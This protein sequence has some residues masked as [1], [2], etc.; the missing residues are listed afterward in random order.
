MIHYNGNILL[1]IMTRSRASKGILASQPQG[2]GSKKSG[3]APTIGKHSFCMRLI[4]RRG[5]DYIDTKPS[6][7]LIL[8]A[9]YILYGNIDSVEDFENGRIVGTTLDLHPFYMDLDDNIIHILSNNNGAAHVINNGII[10]GT[11]YVNNKRVVCYWDTNFVKHDL[12]MYYPYIGGVRAYGTIGYYN[13]CTND[14]PVYLQYNLLY[15]LP[16]NTYT[17][18]VAYFEKIGIIVGY[19]SNGTN[20]VPCYWENYQLYELPI[21][22]YTSGIAYNI[23][24][25]IFMIVGAVSNGTNEVPCCW[26]SS[27]NLIGDYVLHDLPINNYTSGVAYSNNNNNNYT[28]VGF[29]NN[30]TNDVPCYWSSSTDLIEDYVLHELPIDT[31]TSGISYSTYGTL[32]TG[33]V[34][35]GTN[36]VPCYWNYNV[37]IDDY[38]FY[39]LPISTYTSGVAYSS[40][41]NIIVGFV[42]N[43]SRDIPCK[44]TNTEGTFELILLITDEKSSGKAYSINGDNMYI[45]GYVNVGEKEYPCYYENNTI[46]ILKLYENDYYI[47]DSHNNITVLNSVNTSIYFYWNNYIPYKLPVENY[48]NVSIT[49]VFNEIIVGSVSSDGQQFNPCYWENFQFNLL[50]INDYISGYTYGIFNGIIVGNVSDE[51]QFYPCYWENFQFNLL[52]MN[53]YIS[54]YAYEINNGIIV[55]NVSDE[56]QEYP[57]YWENFQLHLLPMNDYVYGYAYSISNRIITGNLYSEGFI[58]VV[59]CYWKI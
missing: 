20:E 41:G 46:N 35:N 9:L 27:T 36:D 11:I 29:V 52:P 8:P 21:D 50:P 58:N 26:S 19:V 25:N 40:D 2:G 37:E 55:G 39:E 17:N 32:I 38:V 7:T 1:Y 43:G 56:Q 24:S 33:Y 10:Y 28:I 45:Y 53:D 5:L 15:K 23:N 4:Q 49:S 48:S 22:T 16:I 6:S 47:S 18:G 51:Q 59:S 54:G 30:E 3:L 44:W 13:D 57:C 14:I 42:T 34:S 12:D 31:Y